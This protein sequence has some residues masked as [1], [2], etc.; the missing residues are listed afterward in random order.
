MSK[1]KD[2]AV[3]S[4]EEFF[5]EQ[6]VR[7][8]VKV[9]KLISEENRLRIMLLLAKEK[10]SFVSEMGEILQLSQTTLSHHLSVLRNADLVLSKREGKNIYYEINK[11]LWRDMGLQFFDFLGKGRD[12]RILDKFVLRLMK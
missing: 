12:V 6:Y 5:P 3:E 4:G 8:S 9:L 2:P 1:M 10:R 7:R 11:P